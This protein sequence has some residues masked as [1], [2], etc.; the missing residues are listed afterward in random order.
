[1]RDK[2]LDETLECLQALGFTEYEG[3]IYLS[4]LSRHPASAYTIS[5]QSG[6]PHARVYDMARRLVKRGLAVSTG[7]KPEMFSPLA[8]A[9]LV[10]KLRR[11]QQ[12]NTD[13]LETRL[14][15][16]RFTP[17]FDPVWNLPSREKALEMASDHI[18]DAKHKVSVGVWTEDFDFLRSAL[19]SAHERGLRVFILLYGNMKINF[20]TVYYHGTEHMPDLEQLG[21]TF[22]CVTD[23][24]CCI[25][26][27]LGG[28]LPCQ[29]VWTR[30]LGLVQS[31]E[32]YMAHD[33]YLAEISAHFGKDLDR[34]FG[35]NFGRLR[36]KFH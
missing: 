10:R 30:N 31:I 5:R 9:E 18:H 16:I 14:G 26:G 7:V 15:S 17:D 22:D 24:A 11:E 23:S 21:R 3:K 35:R 27:T 13:H 28:L 19:E 29:V 25:T 20:G 8:P 1:M 34:L 36:R 32:S 33:F 4:L 2:S 12:L 6:V